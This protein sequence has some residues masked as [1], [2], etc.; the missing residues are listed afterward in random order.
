M[1]TKVVCKVRAPAPDFKGTAVVGKDFKDIS[2]SDYKG[3]YL[4]LLFYP[5]GMFDI[6][7]TILK[8]LLLFAQLKS[9]HSLK[10]LKNSRP[11]TLKLLLFLWTP[12]TLT[13]PG[14]TPQ[15]KKE[16]LENSKSLSLQISP[17]KCALI[18]KF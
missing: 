5:L 1:A 4:V 10:P 2:L 13:W 8:I 17:K 14:L 11:S 15:E 18:T 3:K 9:L 6:K 12:N 7:I 16:E